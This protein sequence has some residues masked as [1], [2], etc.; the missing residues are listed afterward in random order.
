MAE[1]STYTPSLPGRFED[2]YQEFAYLRDFPMYMA[3][4]SPQLS[5]FPGS[6]GD[7]P[8][9][10]SQ[11]A[12]TRDA[13]ASLRQWIR[14]AYLAHLPED[15]EALAANK[16]KPPE[17]F[18]QWIA[19][20]WYSP[21]TVSNMESLVSKTMERHRSQRTDEENEAARR[22]ETRVSIYVAL[23][24]VDIGSLDRTN[25]S[26]SAVMA[27]FGIAAVLGALE[28]TCP[29]GLCV[30]PFFAGT[31]LSKFFEAGVRNGI[32]LVRGCQGSE[33]QASTNKE[34]ADVGA[35]EKS[36]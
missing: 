3:M 10:A 33:H 35:A 4:S 13:L 9:T 21:Y 12:A 2:A 1:P 27:R 20:Q 19:A 24:L 28:S 14:I 30:N 15:R 34:P 17:I 8:F 11:D 26:Y 16:R 7:M 5:L 18:W 6:I 29:S 32:K 36:E 23:M 25:P 22:G 31:M